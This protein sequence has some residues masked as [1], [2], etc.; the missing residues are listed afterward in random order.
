VSST[1][2]GDQATSQVLKT[3]PSSSTVDSNSDDDRPLLGQGGV[4]AVVA[5]PP[6]RHRQLGEVVRA[7]VAEALDADV[8]GEQVEE[9]GVAADVFSCDAVVATRARS[10]QAMAYTVRR[11]IQSREENGL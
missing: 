9:G 3:I 10:C 2:H 5:Q 6:A 8:V 1:N 7:Q 11:L 4:A